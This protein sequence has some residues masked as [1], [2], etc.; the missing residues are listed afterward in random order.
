MENTQLGLRLNKSD[1]STI[2]PFPPRRNYSSLS[3]ADLLEARDAYH[4]YLSGLENVVATAI[5]RYRIHQKDWY[6]THPP[7]EHRPETVRRFKEPRTLSNSIV[8]PWSWPAVLV[9]VR[10]WQ[11]P[12]G[13]GDQLVPRALYLPDGRVIPTCVVLATPDE[14]PEPPIDGPSPVSGLIGGGYSCLRH[15][16]GID[17][18]GSFGCLVYQQGT[19]Y[20][21]TNRHVAGAGGEDVKVYVHGGFHRVGTSANIGVTRLRMLDIFSRWPSNN[22][23][24]TIDAGLVTIDRFDDWTS[25]VFGIGEVGET[26]DATE[27]SV[28]LD[29]IGCP[30]RAFGGTSGVIEGEIQALFYRYQS[31]GGFDYATDVL[32]GPRTGS[33]QKDSPP[34][35][36]QPGDSGTLW[37][38]DPPPTEP[39][40]PGDSAEDAPP[41]RGARAPRLRPIAMQWGGQRFRVANEL[42]SAF[43]LGTFLSTICRALDVEVVRNWSTG[44]DEYW[45]KL[46][47]FAIG[48]KAGDQLSGSLS[49]LIKANQ[50]FIGV[51]DDKLKAGADF[52]VDAHGFVALADVPDYIWVT[53]KGS[54]PNEAIQHFADVDIQDINGGKSLLV[55]CNDDPQ[56]VSAKVWK[57]YFDGFASAGVGP[58]E[59]AI[60][61]RVWQIWNAMVAYLQAKDVIHFVAAAGILGH[62]V[63]DASQPLHC[64]YMHHGVPPMKT[65]HGRKYP[66]P[67]DSPEFQAFKETKP[68]AIHGIYEETMLEVDT[69]GA[70][71]A[72]NQLLAN[73][74]GPQR[75]IK[76]GHEAA[77][78]TVRLMFAAQKRL[79]P[80]K[81]ITAD[82]PNVTGSPKTRATALWN[83][84]T[85]RN[86]TVASLAD[87]VR[88]LA[89]LWKGAWKAGNGNS[90][91]ANKLVRFQDSDFDDIY[92]KDKKFIPSLSLAEMAQSGKFEP[93]A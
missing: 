39:G 25:Q 66:V 82:Q 3:M 18:L 13:L 72:V 67:R 47:H 45:G 30:V 55:R 64:S 76:S 31:L 56:N 68:A 20:A 89:D 9:F 74:S 12:E 63:G 24:L 35:F 84:P 1:L 11:T 15:H 27:Q 43:A 70:L 52:R 19:Y 79:S 29:L 7:D 48:F 42:P 73:A 44:H 65:V 28:T 78:E 26:F 4:V 57:E 36:T 34:P 8:R 90:I 5:G 50:D 49:T 14:T 58:E 51:G 46:G 77:V 86:A 93:P 41:E 16:Q 75:N 92:R 83:K 10:Q 87:S 60:P 6:A 21:L 37:F 80:K 59:G 53:Q 40:V 69:A 85:I 62:Y 23:Y 81:I 22:T 2:R 54:H 32:I 33:A 17:H 91:A 88:L 38:Y 71:T 61:F